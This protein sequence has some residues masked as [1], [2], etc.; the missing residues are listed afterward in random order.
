MPRPAPRRRD[1]LV[2]TAPD[3]IIQDQTPSMNTSPRSRNWRARPGKGRFFGWES[4]E[5]RALLSTTTETFTGPSLS[6]LIQQAYSGTDTAP[7]AIARMEQALETQLKS[8]PLADLK[9]GAVNGNGFVTEVQS[10]ESSYEQNLDKQ[11]SPQFPNVDQILKLQGQAIVADVIALN[12]QESVGLITSARLITDAQ[13]AIATLTN[14]PINALDTP[15]SAYA[16][17]TQTFESDLTALANALGT[18]ASPALTPGQASATGLAETLAYQADLH[19]GLQVLHPNISNEVD[20]AVTTLETAASRLAQATDSATAQSQLK[21]AISTFDT[22]LLD[23]TGVFGPQGVIATVLSRGETF[24]PNLTM[25]QAT[26]ALG[27]VSGTATQGSTATLTA[28]LT[29]PSTGKG[30]AGA[31]VSFTLDGAFAGIA[32]TDSSGVATLTG[33]TTSDA[34]G[35]DSGGV[36]TT[37]AGNI[38]NKPASARGGLVVTS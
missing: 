20:S 19:A 7:A 4:L 36:V 15:L 18:S 13:S 29:S 5:P 3:R 33:V 38:H 26:S 11:L 8:G 17:A 22:A 1:A 31:T 27:S 23:K 28:T 6:D 16:A 34:V 32:V 21:A 10:L 37:F 14:G 24:S 12:Q 25:P 2:D 35:T 9:S 30:I